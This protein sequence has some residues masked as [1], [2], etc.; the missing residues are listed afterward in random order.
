MLKYLLI[1]IICGSEKIS[2]EDDV[3]GGWDVSPERIELAAEEQPII[4]KMIIQIQIQRQYKYK[5]EQQCGFD[6]TR[7]GCILRLV[8]ALVPTRSTN[9]NAAAVCT[10]V[11][12]HPHINTNIE[13]PGSTSCTTWSLY[14]RRQT[15]YVSM[16]LAHFNSTVLLSG[17]P[18]LKVIIYFPAKCAN[19]EDWFWS[20]AFW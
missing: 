18:I 14:F 11:I 9:Y 16:L 6:L 8:A 7:T 17:L 13:T 5:L 10:R 4:I 3:W 12:R 15:L 20:F 1:I 2:R 19:V